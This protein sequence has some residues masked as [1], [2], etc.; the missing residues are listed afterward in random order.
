MNCKI[1]RAFPADQQ[2]EFR[3]YA[4]HYG[5]SARSA[6]ATGLLLLLCSFLAKQLLGALSQE[7]DMLVFFFFHSL[8]FY[9]QPLALLF[10]KTLLP[11]G[12]T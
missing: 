2:F 5:D 11:Q 9:F 4:K 10:G 7:R 1:S 6:S 8:G 12:T 3:G